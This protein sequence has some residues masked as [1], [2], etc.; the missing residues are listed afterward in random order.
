L[1]A[2][3]AGLNPLFLAT[4]FLPKKLRVG[5]FADSAL[6]PRWVVEAFAR[7]ARSEF[8]EI[9]LIRAGDAPPA[10]VPWLFRTEL[11]APLELARYVPHQNLQ[12]LDVA[13]ALGGLDDTLIDGIANFGVWRFYGDGAREVVDGAPLTSSGIKVRLA[14]GAESRLAYQ[15]WSR[16]D[17]L[18]VKRN[19]ERVLA[20]SADFAVRALRDVERFGHG[21]LGQCKSIPDHPQ[22]TISPISAVATVLRNRAQSLLYVEERF[23]AFRPG[24]GAPP[25]SL[26][27]FT[28]LPGRNPF[29]MRDRI[30]FEQDGRIGV[31]KEPSFLMDGEYPFLVEEGPELFMAASGKL[32]RCLEFPRRWQLEGELPCGN[33]TLHRAVDRWW[34]FGTGAF[35]E[36]LELYHAPK[37][38]GPWQPHPRN[39]VK[40]DARNARPAGRLY[41]RN[42]ALYRPAQMQGLGVS[43]NRVVRLTPHDYAERQVQIIPGLRGFNQSSELTV[44]DAVTRRR[45]FT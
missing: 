22:T 17:A 10:A 35:E 25:T 39:P 29:P 36:E 34:L 19:R 24:N 15:S 28:R 40:S 43:V 1:A 26:E 31:T 3:V 14:P 12:D 9:A 7:V 33:A 11:D 30:F 13:F 23:A 42:G 16:T 32:Y 38:G 27:G 4:D 18:S 20:K 2:V 45:R 21:W 44:V 5:L 8:A 6:Q 37:L 41:W